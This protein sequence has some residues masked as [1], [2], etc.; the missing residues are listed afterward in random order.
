MSAEWKGRT[1]GRQDAEIDS[2][3]DLPRNPR[4]RL[5][6][7][8]LS[9][10]YRQGYMGSYHRTYECWQRQKEDEIARELAQN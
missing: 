3:N 5:M 1:H 2:A 4:P 9:D 8:L 10:H 6:P 7:S